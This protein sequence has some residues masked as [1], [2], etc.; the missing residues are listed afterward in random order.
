MGVLP[1]SPRFA[2]LGALIKL[3]S[4]SSISY[5]TNRCIATVY[6]QG[7]ERHRDRGDISVFGILQARKGKSNY[8]IYRMLVTIGK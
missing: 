3:I 8:H 4:G 1:F 6:G 2:G 5:I 7:I